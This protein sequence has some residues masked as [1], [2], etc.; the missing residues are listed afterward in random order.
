[1][2]VVFEGEQHDRLPR[3]FV[4]FDVRVCMRSCVR[5]C[6]CVCVAVDFER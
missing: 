4:Y 2:D 3:T 1:M 6:V 5:V